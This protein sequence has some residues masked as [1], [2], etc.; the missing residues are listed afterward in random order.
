MNYKMVAYILGRVMI[1]MAL[2]MCLPFL[3]A[4]LQKEQTVTGFMVAVAGLLVTGGMVSLKRPK[5]TELYAKEGLIIVA[6]SWI[7]TSLFGA[8]PFHLS[9]EIPSYLDAFFET[10]SGFTTTGA[11][12]L[13]DIEA[14]SSSSLLWRSFTH[15]IGGM[16]V[17][18]FVLAVLPK[19]HATQ[20]MHIMRAEA[21][22]PQVGK[23]VS[24]MRSTA[25]I[26]YGIYIGLTILEIVALLLAGMPLFD[27]I[28]NSFATAGTGGFCLKNASIAAYDSA[29]I[30]GVITVFMLLFGINFTMFYLI[31]TGNVLQ[32]LKSEELR[33]YVFLVAGAALMITLNIMPQYRGFG[34]AFRYAIFQV[35]A[36]ITTTGFVTADFG[37]WPLFS[38]TILMVLMFIGACAGS[39]GG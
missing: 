34:E 5:N 36:I 9:G 7:I 13:T 23:L 39:T 21:P 25:R 18:V 4:I 20:S 37:Q 31:L 10:V 26:L 16:G 1:I 2:L 19:S 35:S 6:L 38:R 29:L 11:T 17:L 22:G 3:I 32:V 30:D 27:S 28:L 33:W 24:R 8:L 12:I 14:L 15:W